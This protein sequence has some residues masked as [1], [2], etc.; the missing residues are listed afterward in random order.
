[1]HTASAQLSLSQQAHAW[2]CSAL[3]VHAWLRQASIAGLHPRLQTLPTCLHLAPFKPRL[4]IQLQS[5]Q[6]SAQVLLWGAAHEPGH[7]G[8]PLLAR[9][10]GLGAQPLQRRSIWGWSPH[11]IPQRRPALSGDLSSLLLGTQ[12]GGT[13]PPCTSKDT[14]HGRCTWG[15]CRLRLD[16]LDRGHAWHGMGRQACGWM[17]TARSGSNDSGKLHAQ[18]W[19]KVTCEV[20]PRPHLHAH[21]NLDLSARGAFGPCILTPQ[22]LQGGRPILMCFWLQRPDTACKVPRNPLPHTA[23]RCSCAPRVKAKP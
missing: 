19:F 22:K 11:H 10:A 20:Q 16:Q 5:Q 6:S 1:M 8:S 17:W 21:V 23:A 3:T 7:L 4:H 12:G 13:G 14:W 2:H 18:W 15:D 9:D